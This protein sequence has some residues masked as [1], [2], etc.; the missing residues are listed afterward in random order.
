[1]DDGPFAW[2]LLGLLVVAF[3]YRQ[4]LVHTRDVP[5]EYLNEQSVIDS[6]RNPNELAIHKS[7]KLDYSQGLRV[8]LG[9]RYSLYKLRNGNL[10]DIWEL[11]MGHVK[12]DPT[13]SIFL[14]GKQ[15][16]LSQLNI[17]ASQIRKVLAE[18]KTECPFDEI[19][20]PVELLFTDQNALAVA[21]ACF[22]S[23]I[24]VHINDG[25]YNNSLS[26][27]GPEV[28]KK[29]GDLVISWKSQILINATQ[30]F[31][32]NAT[33][34]IF[35]NEYTF[36]KDRGIALRVSHRANHKAIACTDFT[37][38]NLVSAVASCIKHLPPQHQITPN[39]RLA[40][41]LDTSSIEG[42]VNNLVKV[43]VS[44]VT[45]AELH[46]ETRIDACVAINP[47]IILT[48][49]ETVKT[50]DKSAIGLD[51]LLKFH[52]LYSLSCNRF[53]TF[54]INKPYPELR[55]I[56]AH[57]SIN[58]A[59]ESPEWKQINASFA[60]HVVEEIGYFNVAGPLLVS[61]FYDF[62]KFSSNISVQTRTHGAVAQA[63]EVKLVDFDGKLP[64]KIAV[65]GYNI[66]KAKTVMEK[67]GETQIFPDN[68]GFYQLPVLARW[69]LDGCMYVMK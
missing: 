7:T 45:G 55:L 48:S 15:V 16:K 43:F 40:V 32:K 50:L 12:K 52:R 1:M 38:S 49:T 69:G 59:K 27:R 8:G 36:E 5:E 53:S 46:L 11:A 66:G 44:L 41:I 56:I 25:S 35:E 18:K 65:R 26:I 23:Q 20:I 31:D 19:R 42:I 6:T 2:I 17:Q 60:C 51:K 29:D 57:R 61:D 13:T 34:T 47:T 67:V 21:I 33:S 58:T 30:T 37:Q 14:Q 54:I 28:V 64:G 3:L 22:T 4:Y 63:N 10:Y 62:R 39:D 68:E 9:I 24:T